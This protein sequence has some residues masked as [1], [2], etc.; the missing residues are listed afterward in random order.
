[1]GDKALTSSWRASLGPPRRMTRRNALV[2]STICCGL[3]RHLFP[4]DAASRPVIASRD[5]PTPRRQSRCGGAP[6]QKRFRQSATH[7]EGGSSPGRPA[8]DSRPQWPPTPSP[9]RTTGILFI[10]VRPSQ[11]RQDAP[12]FE[13]V[14]VSASPT[15]PHPT[16]ARPPATAT[17][18]LI[19]V[20]DLAP[21][22]SGPV[23]RHGHDS[24]YEWRLT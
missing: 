14:A 12:D 23:P 2:T 3:T 15:G 17:V 22:P 1:M 7:R 16:A 24:Q 18:Y 4:L 20:P 6:D 5:P 11:P 19:A 9:Y 10:F 13:R 8:L 21:R